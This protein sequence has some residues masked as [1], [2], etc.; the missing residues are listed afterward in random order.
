MTG[1]RLLD[2]S[3]DKLLADCVTPLLGATPSAR[4]RRRSHI[5]AARWSFLHGARLRNLL[6]PDVITKDDYLLAPENGAQQQMNDGLCL[7]E[8]LAVWGTDV[9]GQIHCS[10]RPNGVP[11]F[12]SLAHGR[13]IAKTLLLKSGRVLVR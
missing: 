2:F 10:A 7:Q 3:H 8:D 4:R 5:A 1:K 12:L 6:H 9:P 13:F 11:E